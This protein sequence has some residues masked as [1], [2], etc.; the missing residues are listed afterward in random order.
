MLGDCHNFRFTWGD[1]IKIGHN[2][3]EIVLV[4]DLS[5]YRAVK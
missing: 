4:V 2:F 5:E 1:I 3:R